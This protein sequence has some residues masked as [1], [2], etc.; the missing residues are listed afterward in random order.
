[1][2]KHNQKKADQLGMPQGTAS[3]RLRKSII[4]ML[5]KMQN[6]NFCH[7][8]GGEIESESE[9]SIEHKEAWLDSDDPVKRFFDLNNIAFSHLICNVGAGKRAS[10]KGSLKPISHGTDSGYDYHGCRC[11]DC[12]EHKRKRNKLRT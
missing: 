3:N 5:L 12:K 6:L 2:N 10:G 8:C 4:F 7:Q 9:L 11:E 1:M